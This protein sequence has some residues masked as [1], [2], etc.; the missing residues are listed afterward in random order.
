MYAAGLGVDAIGLVFTP[1]SS[2]CV[3]TGQAAAI[4]AVVPPFVDVVALFMDNTADRVREVM[5]EVKPS[6][7]QFHGAESDAFCAAFGLPWMKA[8]AMKSVADVGAHMREWPR[9]CGFVLDGHI[10]GAPGG[11]GVTFDWARVPDARE[12]ALVLAGGL[13]ADNIGQ[14]VRRVRPWAVDVSSGI[15]MSPGIKSAGKMQAF[16]K[17]VQCADQP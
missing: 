6:L 11:Q 7:L 15:E 1:M 5:D 13:D 17:A 3:G 9:A 4:A 8:V 10:A 2:R 16:V 12:R 14:A